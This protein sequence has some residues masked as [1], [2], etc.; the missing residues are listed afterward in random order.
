MDRA[1]NIDAVVI[2]PHGVY[3]VEVKG[4]RGTITGDAFEWSV[5]GRTRRAPTNL[6]ER[7]AKVLKS[8]LVDLQQAWGRRAGQKA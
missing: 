8:H 7:K 2:T 1:L 6:I 4:W 3:A 5:N